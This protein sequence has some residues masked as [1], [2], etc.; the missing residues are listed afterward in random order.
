[1]SGRLI[2]SVSR[3]DF[4]IYGAGLLVPLA[5]ETIGM[6]G[7]KRAGSGESKTNQIELEATPINIVHL[8]YQL[9]NIIL[10]CPGLEINLAALDLMFKSNPWLRVY[11]KNGNS[12]IDNLAFDTP[13]AIAGL[14]DSPINQP[15]DLAQN[16][17]IPIVMCAESYEQLLRQYGYTIEYGV[18]R[19]YKEHRFDKTTSQISIGVS[20]GTG[21]S[22]L[23]YGTDG[24][25]V[26]KSSADSHTSKYCI[27]S[28]YDTIAAIHRLNSA[29]PPGQFTQ[30]ESPDQPE[31][32]IPP[33]NPEPWRDVPGIQLS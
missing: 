28:I 10:H 2:E 4:I 32:Q 11:L 1:M 3:R 15:V 16:P 17:I 33:V 22:T 6:G 18:L 12:L 30:P 14:F 5:G 13:N 9:E 31:Q 26:A 25:V 21:L 29:Q 24:R 8:E 23:E 20:A 19:Y 7:G 27:E